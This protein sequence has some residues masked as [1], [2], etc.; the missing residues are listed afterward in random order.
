MHT[1]IWFSSQLAHLFQPKVDVQ[2]WWQEA[3][4]PS[5]RGTGVPP[6]LGIATC[7][8]PGAASASMHVASAAT[9]LV[10]QAAPADASPYQGTGSSSQ[11]RPTPWS[12]CSSQPPP[13]PDHRVPTT[14]PA[15]FPWPPASDAD[16]SLTGFR[17]V[18][19]PFRLRVDDAFAC[20]REDDKDWIDAWDT[21]SPA[22]QT[23]T[24]LSFLTFTQIG[25]RLPSSW[26]SLPVALMVLLFVLISA[27]D[28]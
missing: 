6:P 27:T 20:Y 22:R 9:M 21:N 26:N 24:P 17:P 8:A 14:P 15:G 16:S 3:R 2:M 12:S 11:R 10:V 13:P 18:D 28:V 25:S 7:S 1:V 5:V 19:C 23:G 4:H